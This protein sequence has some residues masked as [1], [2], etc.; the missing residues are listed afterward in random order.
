M[1]CH[2]SR[3]RPVL[4]MNGNSFDAVSRSAGASG[5]MNRALRSG[6]KKPP[7]AKK[8]GSRPTR[9]RAPARRPDRAHRRLRPRISARRAEIEI[10]RA[11][12][13]ERR[14]R[15][16]LAEN[17]GGALVGERIREAHAPRDLRDDPPVGLRF[18]RQR[19]EAALA[20]DAPL[21][22]RDRAVLLAPCGGGKK[23]V[24]AAVQRVVR[25]RRSPRQRTVRASSAPR[26]T[27]PARGSDTAGLVAITHKAL[28][29]PNSIASNIC[30]ALRPSCV[31][32]FGAFQKRRTRSISR[33]RNSCAPPTGWRGRRPRV[34]PSRSAGRSARTAPC[35]ACRC[36]RSR[37]GS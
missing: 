3:T 1:V 7:S 14:E 30:T 32:M 9:P 34:R 27:A 31:A 24:S 26:T 4:S 16:M 6:V 33:A 12:V 23:N 28:I 8:R 29:C 35:R 13:L 22:V 37:D 19:Q 18:A 20:R 10:A 36:G 17:I 15:G 2:W 5:A 25:A 11:V 21:G